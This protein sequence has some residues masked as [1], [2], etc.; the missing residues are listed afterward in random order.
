MAEDFKI[1]MQL[2]LPLFLLILMASQ[3]AA[4]RVSG[5]M[6]QGRRRLPLAVVLGIGRRT[7]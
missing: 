5:L 3:Q 2:V 1:T 7:L 6:F 4:N